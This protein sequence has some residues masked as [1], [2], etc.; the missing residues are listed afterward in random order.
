MNNHESEVLS[1]DIRP[2]LDKNFICPKCGSTHYEFDF[3][4]NMGF[5][6]QSIVCKDCRHYL[7]LYPGEAS[8]YLNNTEDK[9]VD[10][11]EKRTG[12][13][14]KRNKFQLFSENQH[15]KKN[16]KINLKQRLKNQIRRFSWWLHTTTDKWIIPEGMYKELSNKNFEVVDAFIK[17]KQSKVDQGLEL[18]DP[19]FTKF[20]A[21]RERM[22]IIG[23]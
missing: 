8:M 18:N 6:T 16:Q 21:I 2:W 22:Q 12:I 14:S 5:T 17:E 15:V 11:W 10:L 9:I 3:H 7:D 4:D 23:E 1:N 20:K 13:F 19:E